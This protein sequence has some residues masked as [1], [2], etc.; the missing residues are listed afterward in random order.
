MYF[1]MYVIVLYDGTELEL[2]RD[3]LFK[4]S[5]VEKKRKFQW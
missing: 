4:F 3:F 2:Q 5:L 1:Q